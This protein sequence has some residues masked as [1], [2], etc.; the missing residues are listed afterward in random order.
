MFKRNPEQ[1][2]KRW[3]KIAKGGKTRFILLRGVVGWGL[4]MFV[5]MA[6]VYPQV[7]NTG[8]DSYNKNY[9]LMS[10]AIWLAGGYGFGWIMWHIGQKQYEANSR[11]TDNTL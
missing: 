6:L 1:F 9:L 10:A 8:T 7:I 2:A 5:L 3:S 11:D 4:P